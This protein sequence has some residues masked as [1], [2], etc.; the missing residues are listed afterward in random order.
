MK[1]NDIERKTNSLDFDKET[2]INGTKAR[3][4]QQKNLL[5]ET[6]KE[7]KANF[8]KDNFPLKIV[9][10]EFAGREKELNA[11][12]EHDILHAKLIF[13]FT[14]EQ[15]FQ[16]I[17]D[18]ITGRIIQGLGNR[19]FTKTFRIEVPHYGFVEEQGAL[20]FQVVGN[21]NYGDAKMYK[22][23]GELY[24]E[25]VSVFINKEREI[26]VG[27]KIFLKPK[28]EETQIYEDEQNIRLY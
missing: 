3:F 9:E 25:K 8:E 21:V 2:E 12:K 13:F 24:G 11:K 19:V 17:P 6:I 7:N 23:T 1:A 26:D 4:S 16:L 10:A 20:P 22:C 27:A 18:D 5:K 14:Y 15:I 28:L